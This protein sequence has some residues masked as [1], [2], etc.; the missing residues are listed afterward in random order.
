MSDLR[1]ARKITLLLFFIKVLPWEKR[2]REFYHTWE[3][4]L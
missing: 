1:E 4:S 3:M 2:Y